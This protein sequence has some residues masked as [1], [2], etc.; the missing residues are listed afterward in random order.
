MDKKNPL[1]KTNSK[2][3]IE[4]WEPHRVAVTL[5]SCHIARSTMNRLLIFSHFYKLWLLWAKYINMSQMSITL[6]TYAPIID[7]GAVNV[8]P[9]M[10]DILTVK[11]KFP[12]SEFSDQPGFLSVFLKLRWNE[13]YDQK[14]MARKLIGK[15]TSC[16]SKKKICFPQIINQIQW[17]FLTW[18]LLRYLDH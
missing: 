6:I 15:V 10:L 3:A 7:S 18:S 14:F 12:N 4:I 17:T 2:S 16:K 5:F 1:I 13:I 9:C 8:S 11:C